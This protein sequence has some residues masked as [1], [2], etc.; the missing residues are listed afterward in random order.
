MVS[1]IP[2][3]KFISICFKFFLDTWEHLREIIYLCIVI[4]KRMQ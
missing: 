3:I 1:Q 2:T 4:K